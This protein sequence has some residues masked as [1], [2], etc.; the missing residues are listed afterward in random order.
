MNLDILFFFFQILFNHFQRGEGR[1]RERERSTDVQQTSLPSLSPA[2]N[3]GSG[4]QPRHV[5]QPGIE[6]A[7]FGSQASAQSTEPHQPGQNWIL[8]TLQ[9]TCTLKGK[10]N[11]LPYCST[12]TGITLYLTSTQCTIFYCHLYLWTIDL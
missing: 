12:R 10:Q 9:G 8:N 4:P 11:K 6:P 2:P 7:T 1:E 5:P 3:W